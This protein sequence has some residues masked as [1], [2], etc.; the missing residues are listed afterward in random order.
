MSLG[1]T[2]DVQASTCRGERYLAD[3]QGSDG[4]WRDYWLRPGDSEDWV[5]ACCTLALVRQPAAAEAG[6]AAARAGGR[7]LL[8]A[9][10]PGGWGY[11]RSTVTDADSSAWALRALAALGWAGVRQGELL[12]RTYLDDDGRAHTFMPPEEADAWGH[13]HA[14]VTP[15]VGIALIA[16]GASPASI[17]Q[18]RQSIVADQSAQG[19][20]PSFWWAGNAYATA[21]SIEF[22][23]HS[24]GIPEVCAQRAR[25]WLQKTAQIDHPF[26]ATQ[27]LSIGA[28]LGEPCDRVLD[29]LLDNQ[30]GEGSWPSSPALLTPSRESGNAGSEGHHDSECVLGTAMVLMALKSWLA[31]DARRRPMS[32]LGF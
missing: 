27:C 16:C 8:A 10:R 6:M 28:L 30:R 1:L 32:R 12:L 9:R 23:S 29:A 24:G 31:N 20:W 11:N 5:S 2:H 21:R 13:A 25:H 22:L 3:R 19:D 18:V 4:L 17:A 26:D 15:V 14:D 7:A